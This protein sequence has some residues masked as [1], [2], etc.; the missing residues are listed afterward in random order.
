MTLEIGT[1]VRVDGYDGVVVS[2]SLKS[3]YGHCPDSMVIVRVP[4]GITLKETRYC[5]IKP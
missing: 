5:E 1:K 3:Y 2:N 4:G